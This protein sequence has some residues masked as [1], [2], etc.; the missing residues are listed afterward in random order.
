MKIECNSCTKIYLVLPEQIGESG[1]KVKCTNCNH[2]WYQHLEEP[3]NDINIKEKKVGKTRNLVLASVVFAAVAWLSV[4]IAND[5]FP[6]E[7]S[8]MY[9]TISTYK[10]SIGYKLGYKKEQ[11]DNANVK[12]LAVDKFYQ[13]YLFLSNLSSS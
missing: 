8:K 2:V 10:D 12:T 13:D 3:S 9:K 11:T 6:R 4:T 1:R 5:V 7:M